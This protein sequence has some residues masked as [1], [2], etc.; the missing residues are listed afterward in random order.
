MKFFDRFSNRGRPA[1]LV[2]ALALVATAC[3]DEAAG[4]PTAADLVH[5]HGLEAVPGG[6]GLY[7]ATHTGLFKVNGSAIEAVGNATHDLMGFTAAGPQDL[8][9]SG[10]PDL[11][12]DELLVDDKPPLLGLV[13]SEDG[14]NW[15]PLSL[16]GDVDF[17]S[18]VAA[19]DQV[20]GLD[21][22]TG[23]LMVSADRKTWQTR[24][25]G[26]PFID[27]A[28][29]P[30]DADALVATT[31][32]G[33]TASDDGGKSWTDRSSQRA[34]FLSWTPAGLF[35]VSPEGNVVRS[36]DGGQN[37]QP[38]GRVE[39]S[40]EA[41]LVTKEAIYVAVSEA[42]IM[43]STDGGRNFDFLVRTDADA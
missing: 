30:D 21:S 41:L 37:W 5:V 42:G 14:E 25:K 7:V 36:D 17:H 9:A 43:H 23:A 33:I 28:V 32:N 24:S 35:G 39:G 27:F 20:Y 2:L 13:H 22:Q 4:G 18:L 29:S 11:R 12:V 38:L 15:E 3:G 6:E 10:H 26:L 19:H 8:L 34:V 1:A 16:L 40:P 31:Q